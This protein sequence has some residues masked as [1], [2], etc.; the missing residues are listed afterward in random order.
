MKKLLYVFAALLI[1]SCSTS[2]EGSNASG[3][4]FNPPAWIQGTWK[5][6]ID[7]DGI[8]EDIGFKF[9]SNDMC[10]ILLQ[11]E[12]CQKGLFDTMRQSGQKVTVE[13]IISDT[14]YSAKVSYSAGQSMTYSFKKISK[15]K[16]ETGSLGQIYD[17]Q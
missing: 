1:F 14:F 12:Q 7:G 8:A 16:I 17:K 4:D 11:T 15:T 5:L 13:E 6:D 3:S 2:D 10:T 9:T